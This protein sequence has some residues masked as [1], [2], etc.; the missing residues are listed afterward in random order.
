[1]H[2]FGFFERIGSL[3][4]VA[5]TPGEAELDFGAEGTGHGS[6]DQA[7]EGAGAGSRGEGNSLISKPQI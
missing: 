6:F 7:D 5:G 2:E 1:M 4:S 3:E